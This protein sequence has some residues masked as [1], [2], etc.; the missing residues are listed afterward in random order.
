MSELIRLLSKDT[1][2][3]RHYTGWGKNTIANHSRKMLRLQTQSEGQGQGRKT[4]RTRE[5]REDERGRESGRVEDEDGEEA[6]KSWR[7]EGERR[8]K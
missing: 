4:K 6:K 1:G 7:K 5:G 2:S 8:M 3:S